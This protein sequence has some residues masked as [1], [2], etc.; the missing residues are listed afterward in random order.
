MK[1]KPLPLNKT[2]SLNEF[3]DKALERHYVW[4]L[5][6]KAQFPDFYKE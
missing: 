5:N 6:H 1:I 2:T 3:L 4:L